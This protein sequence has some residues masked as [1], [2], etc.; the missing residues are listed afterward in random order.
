MCDAERLLGRWSLTGYSL[1]FDDGSTAQ[2][3]GARPFG[4]LI[5]TPGWMSAHLVAEG[6]DRSYMSYCGEW[7]VEGALVRHRVHA[8]DWPGL[9]G[10]TLTRG[11]DWDGDAL[12]LTARGAPYGERRGEGRLRWELQA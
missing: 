4:L 9:I 11:I 3:I 8:C 12:V 6:W 10:K 7:A 5:Y 2:P 1:H